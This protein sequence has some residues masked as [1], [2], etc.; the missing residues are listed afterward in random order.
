[1]NRALHPALVA[2][3]LGLLALAA[4]GAERVVPSIYDRIDAKFE[5][6]PELARALQHP[7]AELEAARWMEGEWRVTARVFATAARGEHVEQGTSVV[8]R[9]LDRWLAIRDE[10]PQGVHDVGYLGY[11]PFAK[12]WVSL[13][14]DSAGNAT[15]RRSDGGWNADRL[16]FTGPPLDVLGEKL[17]LR[18]TIT[19]V[20]DREYR[21]LNEERMG[22]LWRRCD[23]YVYRRTSAGEEV[24]N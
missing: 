9:T 15:L 22:E 5:R 18:T 23:E 3:L 8:A 10:Y 4:L 11:D 14:V 1:M 6:D 19:K 24:A 2:L 16:V 7:P 21:V 13:G 17:T 20:S 12:Q